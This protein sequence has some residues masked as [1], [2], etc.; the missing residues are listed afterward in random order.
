MRVVKQIPA[1]CGNSR[2][3]SSTPSGGQRVGTRTA[4]PGEATS[5]AMSPEPSRRSTVTARIEN[6]T[7]P[8]PC[9]RAFARPLSRDGILSVPPL[10]KFFAKCGPIRKIG[11]RTFEWP[12]IALPNRH[13]LTIRKAKLVAL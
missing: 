10:A 11:L 3:N 1:R 13:R 6:G 8:R 5:A 9:I 4:K 12:T 7:H 2:T